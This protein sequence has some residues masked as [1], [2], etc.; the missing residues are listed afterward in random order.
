MLGRRS[1]SS[2]CAELSF[3]K[4]ETVVVVNKLAEIHTQETQGSFMPD[5][6]NDVLTKALGTKE[7]PGRIRDFIS[8]VPWK[9]GVP[10]DLHKYKRCRNTEQR[11]IEEFKAAFEKCTRRRRIKK[12][13]NGRT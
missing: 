11:R 9:K 7:H 4:P 6:E 1:T 10:H 13:R 3:S 8:K 2:L 12:N 5:R